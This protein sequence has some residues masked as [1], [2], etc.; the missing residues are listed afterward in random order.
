MFIVL[1]TFSENRSK[2]P[3]YMQGHKDWIQRGFDD[4]I[5]LAVGS[6]KPNKGGGILVHNTSL[7]DL[8]QRVSEDPFVAGKIVDAEILE[9][10][11]NRVDE[12]LDFLLN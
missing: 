11:P 7:D 9:M 8:Q 6:L 2:A 3:D 5:F 4:D 1:L 12:R 10:A